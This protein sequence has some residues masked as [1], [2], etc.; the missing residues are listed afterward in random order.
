M[1]QAD[2]I[3][4]DISEIAALLHQQ[5]WAEKNA[6]NFSV[7]VDF[8]IDVRNDNY[9]QL[10]GTFPHLANS[11]FVVTGKDKRMRDIAKMPSQN[12]VIVK[13]NSSGNS[14]TVISE[15]NI[16]P[17]S[18]LPTHFAIHNMIAERGSH[19]RAVIHSH[20][21]ELIALTHISEYCDQ[22]KLNNL[23]WE[24]HPETIM[25]I[26]KGVGFVPFMMPGSAEIAQATVEILKSHQIAL[27]EKHGV[28]SI[29]NNLNDCYDL[30]DI[31]AK[32]AKIY[33]LCARTGILPQGLNNDQL[34]ELGNI[35]F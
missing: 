15:E 20:V 32:S 29:A 2:Q 30:I 8:H 1:K 21:T 9:I 11:I 24:M 3:Y 31:I 14:Y 18:E 4:N 23:L 16:T 12:T 33:F 26:P 7:K 35:K 27:W 19:E 22:N 5:G 34:R 13:L 25:F 6:G 17:T 28:F 10:D